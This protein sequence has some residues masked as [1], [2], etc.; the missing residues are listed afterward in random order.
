MPKKKSEQTPSFEQALAELESVVAK[1]ESGDLTL[2]DSLK[3]Y[4]RGMALSQT[5]QKMLSD[6]EQR[7]Q[8]LSENN[9]LETFR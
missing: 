4:E 3:E 9:E 7:V 1:M 6:A 2:E 5:C 8:I